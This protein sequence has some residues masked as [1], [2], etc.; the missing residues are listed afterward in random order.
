MFKINVITC[1]GEKHYK[2][3]K[4]LEAAF[5]CANNLVLASSDFF[6]A[7]VYDAHGMMVYKIKNTYKRLG[8]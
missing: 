6:A 2:T 3:C 8:L 4:T 1:N 7:A 5:T